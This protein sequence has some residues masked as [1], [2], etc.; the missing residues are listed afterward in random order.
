MY[1][2]SNSDFEMLFEE[3]LSNGKTLITRFQNTIPYFD[4]HPEVLWDIGF[5]VRDDA[6]N[7]IDDIT[8][9]HNAFEI[10]R[11]I[12]KAVRV[13]T[14]VKNPKYVSFLCKEDRFNIYK[15]KIKR[16]FGNWI[17]F[18]YNTDDNLKGL[19][20]SKNGDI[21]FVEDEN[22]IHYC[23]GGIG[24]MITMVDGVIASAYRIDESAAQDILDR[25]LVNA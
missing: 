15:N 1:L 14:I 10:M 17:E 25:Y 12:K 8:N 3:R 4:D 2:K 6:G 11:K 9:D 5:A 22:A 19:M 24:P 21:P 7:T 13:F 16:I 23:L 20:L 18:H